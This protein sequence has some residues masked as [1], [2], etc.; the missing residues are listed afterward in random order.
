MSDFSVVI[1]A[2]A[3]FARCYYY[4]LRKPVLVLEITKK[5][6]LI[7]LFSLVVF[8][9]WT[10]YT[11]RNLPESGYSLFNY[12]ANG[13]RKGDL[14]LAVEPHPELFELKNPYDPV[15]N[16][17]YRLHDAS[18]FNGRYFS[19]FGPV[20]AVLL[21]IP[22]Q[23]IGYELLAWQAC[24]VLAVLQLLLS[25]NV[26]KTFFATK[27][28]LHPLYTALLILVI[29]FGSIS[30]ILLRRP[31]IYEISILSGS[32]FLTLSILFLG[33]C[34]THIKLGGV[35]S[36]CALTSVILAF[37]SR[38]SH[39][40]SIFIVFYIV[41]VFGF[42]KKLRHTLPMILI[43][44]T[45]FGLIFLYNLKRFDSIF[46]F[47]I[48]YQLSGFENRLMPR[49][50][51]S[52][53]WPKISGDLFTFPVLNINFPFVRMGLPNI[54]TALGEQALEPSIG[55]VVLFPWIFRIAALFVSVRNHV[56]L[57]NAPIYYLIL[58]LTFA[59]IST[60]IIQMIA[61][62]GITIRYIADFSPFIILASSLLLFHVYIEFPFYRKFLI[63]NTLF[64]GLFTICFV[65]LISLTGYFN[66]LYL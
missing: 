35:W 57:H 56:K 12:L 7:S 18:F 3:F 27:I 49:F 51:L 1:L 46:E 30:P 31:A 13:F 37:W 65:F 33:K 26:L 54:P 58:T 20:P 15:E 25:Y 47:G 38:P 59:S 29:G 24:F 53:I 39:L 14:H 32:L 45:S 5:A 6:P 9:F 22:A 62:P 63:K 48:K 16:E 36:S 50:N 41:Y 10:T 19:Y 43:A 23:L 52:W 64:F 42:N 55:L 28:E 8:Y 34:L 4:I 61:I 40:V 60:F 17:S 2:L 66:P 21:Y 11:S 44:S